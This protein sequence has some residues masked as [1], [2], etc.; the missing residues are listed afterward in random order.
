MVGESGR[1]GSE[2][3]PIIVLNSLSAFLYDMEDMRDGSTNTV[4]VIR[5][6]LYYNKMLDT[7]EKRIVHVVHREKRFLVQKLVDTRYNDEEKFHEL[8]VQ[9][10]DFETTE[11]TLGPLV[12]IIEYSHHLVSDF[13]KK[14]KN[15]S[16]QAET[17]SGVIKNDKYT[18]G[19]SRNSQRLIDGFQKYE[20]LFRA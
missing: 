20:C 6:R 8:Q 14:R 5:Q 9:W 15:F 3:G 7:T 10:K 12:Q 18:S 2:G 17:S 1:L 11:N 19:K 16:L 13:L 4:H